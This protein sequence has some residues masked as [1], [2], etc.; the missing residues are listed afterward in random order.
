MSRTILLLQLLEDE[1]GVI[2]ELQEGPK[3]RK[4]AGSG[5]HLSLD[6]LVADKRNEDSHDDDADACP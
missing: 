6:T 5:W 1:P 3:E 2:V 4:P